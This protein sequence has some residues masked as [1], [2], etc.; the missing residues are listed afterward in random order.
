MTKSRQS[1]FTLIELL[2]VIAIIAI[3]A[4]M[5]LPALSQAR[6]KARAI[7]CTSNLKQCG[8]GYFMYTDDN[9]E[10]FPLGSGWTAPATIIANKAEWH[11]LVKPYVVDGKI[12]NCPSVNYTSFSSYGSTDSSLGYGVAF[13]RNLWI[14][15]YGGSEYSIPRAGTL[16]NV[17]SPSNIMLLSDGYNN[18]MRWFNQSGLGTNYVWHTTRHTNRCNTLFVDGHVDGANLAHVTST[19]WAS[20]DMHMNPNGYP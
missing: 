4:S 15:G 17:K 6:E 18:Y 2:V 11:I 7:S 5:L 8:L 12:F 3:L 13:S 14:N 20:S 1:G 9:K 10:R 19:F 16:G